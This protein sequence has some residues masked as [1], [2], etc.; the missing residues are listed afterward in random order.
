MNHQSD[1]ILPIKTYLALAG[2]L[3]VLTGVTVAVSFINAGGWN[4]VIAL[5]VASLKASL[6][7][8][9]FMHLKY[10]S[11]L[12]LFVFLS[13]LFFVAVFIIFTMF[14]TARRDDLY[15]YTSDPI[16]KQAPIYDN[17][18]ADSTKH[19]NSEQH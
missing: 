3:F 1:H 9:Y 17:L 7:A 5:G 19:E 18:P 16:N 11:K 2:A 4:A 14:D 15:D 10:D 6:V 12:N 13:A 8:L